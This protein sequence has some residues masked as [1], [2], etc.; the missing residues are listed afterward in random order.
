MKIHPQGLSRRE[1]FATTGS[2]LAAACVPAFAAGAVDIASTTDKTVQ[3]R[4]L[5]SR[6]YKTR[7]A[8]GER[9][10]SWT[11]WLLVETVAPRPLAVQAIDLQFLSGRQ[12]VRRTQYA[13]DGV[14]AFTITPPFAPKLADGSPSPT[15]I[16]WPQAVR[17]R[18]S[19]AAA[20]KIDAMQ[21]DLELGESGKI[22]RAS[23]L[24][25]IETF[26]QKTALIYPFKGRG[27]VT[28][29]GVTNGGHRNRSGQFALDCV[30]LDARYAVYLPGS[31]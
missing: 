25:P 20:T 5:P 27:I 2:V 17:I 15:P 8:G 1:L 11:L 7:D 31:G 28:Q 14:R 6:L 13:G 19:E 30:G 10:E 9:T 29:A 3:L 21:V 12:I 4:S 22:V 26:T 23:A 16:Y 24:F 18:C